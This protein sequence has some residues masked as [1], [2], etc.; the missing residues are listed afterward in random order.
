MTVSA[1]QFGD[2]SMFGYDVIVADPPWD[3]EN[4]SDAG[5]LKGADPHYKVMT[6]DAIKALRVGELARGDCL[7]L[8]WTT[9]W[10][11]ATCQAQD[12]A[13]AWG[14]NPISEMVWQKRTASGKTRMGPGYRVRTMHEPILVCTTGNPLHQPLPSSFDGIARA[15][16]RKPE[17]F[18]ELITKHTPIAVRCDLFSRETRDGFA[19]WGDECEKFDLIAN[20]SSA[21][22]RP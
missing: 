11:M 18:Y 6:A 22:S 7:L 13:R 19:A 17:E 16:S 20:Q 14:F 2:L 4:Y 15:H 10:A 1:W 5:T 21:A 12:V 3:F 8:L 9:G